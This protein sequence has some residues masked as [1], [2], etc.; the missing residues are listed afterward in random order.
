LP[1]L[2]ETAARRTALRARAPMSCRLP[3]GNIWIDLG[4]LHGVAVGCVRARRRRR[5][6]VL[7]K[8]GANSVSDQ[9]L[10]ALGACTSAEPS[11]NQHG[12]LDQVHVSAVDAE[13][14][15]ATPGLAAHTSAIALL[16]QRRMRLSPIRR[17]LPVMLTSLRLAADASGARS[18]AIQLGLVCAPRRTSCF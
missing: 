18:T 10:L 7:M 11:G 4:L 8:S 16:E 17:R 5:A 12:F 2:G 6:G 1:L 14:W 9:E 3:C 13:R 15:A